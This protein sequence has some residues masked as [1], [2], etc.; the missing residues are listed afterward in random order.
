MIVRA[1]ISQDRPA[2]GFSIVL[3]D[4]ELTYGTQFNYFDSNDPLHMFSV[5]YGRGVVKTKLQRQYTLFKP[6]GL[7][8]F[9]LSGNLISGRSEISLFGG[10][11]IGTNDLLRLIR[12]ASNDPTCEGF[13]IR[14]GA[15]SESLAS[16]ALIQ[17]IRSELLMARKKGKK[18]LAYIN[19]WARLPEYYLATAA[20]RIVIPELGNISHL[21]LELEVT[22]LKKF[23][24]NFGFDSQIITGGTYKG[25]SNPGSPD[26]TDA[27]RAL[28]K[29]IV[30]DLYH[31]VLFDIK[32]ARKLDWDKVAHIFDGRIIT[33]RQAKKLGLVDDLAYWDSKSMGIFLSSKLKKTKPYPLT[34][35]IDIP[36]PPSIFSPH[37]RIAV[38]EIDGPIV[39]GKSGS[40]DL[41]GGKV[42]GSD[43]VVAILKSLKKKSG[44]K[45]VL[46]RINS[47][48]GSMLA[49]D[50]ILEAILTLK[51]SGKK[52]Y[53]SMGNMAASG[54]YYIA[55]GAD[56]IYANKST[57]TGSIG[58]I[59]AHSNNSEFNRILG[60]KKESIKTGRHMDMFSE[61]R[62]LS[63]EETTMLEKHIAEY[64]QIFTDKLKQQRNL[65]DSE[66][67][68][69]A[70]GQLIIGE[71]ALELKLIDEIGNFYD[72]IH[73]LSKEANI[74]G[75][76]ELHFYRPQLP[77]LI[78]LIQ[79]L[80][81]F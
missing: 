26:L 29:T 66:I 63:T 21:G 56:K 71:K 52:V 46:L 27:E 62:P 19:G 76:P 18:V 16:V 61:N 9:H 80:F 50:Q 28:F 77:G 53:A 5:T 40:N 68:T 20:D 23:M 22:K 36:S 72:A 4:L 2:A 79:Q 57:L 34:Q 39:G 13:I 3:S 78:R 14:L 17:E 15:L 73:N 55:M 38:I 41:F 43:D 74:K 65:T 51:S 7:A 44:I 58:V 1:G 31:H 48:G 47:P 35:F 69:I 25:A 33:A 11:K 59:S 32:S 10:H 45:G 75:E 30:N 67:E 70:Q 37:N 42:T 60:I 12:M 24:N 64:Y 6:S 81:R 8:E 54:G 49:S